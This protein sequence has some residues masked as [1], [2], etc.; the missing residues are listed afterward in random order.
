MADTSAD[1]GSSDNPAGQ[2]AV[3][4]KGGSAT[5]RATTTRTDGG[6]HAARIA[7]L[8]EIFKKRKNPDE[9][10]GTNEH[11]ESVQHLD[12]YT[13][14]GSTTL[15]SKDRK[16]TDFNELELGSNAGMRFP[17]LDV[18]PNSISSLNTDDWTINM[19]PRV[20]KHN[21][22]FYS[23][24]YESVVSSLAGHKKAYNSE[25]YGVL[26]PAVDL[27]W[28]EKPH[29]R[30]FYQINGDSLYDTLAEAPFGF[31][32]VNKELAED[33]KRDSRKKQRV[34][35]ADHSGA[36][37]YAMGMNQFRNK[38]IL[39]PVDDPSVETV[40]TQ[41]MCAKNAFRLNDMVLYAAPQQRLQ[42]KARY[43]A[44]RG[45]TADGVGFASV[46][47]QQGPAVDGQ[48]GFTNAQNSLESTQQHGFDGYSAAGTQF[49]PAGGPASAAYVR[50][51]GG[52]QA[53]AS[54]V[55]LTTNPNN[56]N[57]QPGI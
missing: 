8:E 51:V 38:T 50:G 33:F 18:E 39:H 21:L 2:A 34:R 43:N 46:A 13:D 49:A 12:G 55:G 53:G 1:G 37:I 56:P 24:A 42:F 32:K 6:T 45:A 48:F 44:T 54:A 9:Q 30:F 17:L 31:K 28:K 22:D 35:S 29:T 41:I 25:S 36:N 19:Q 27:N 7:R 16:I 11:T 14:K 10:A 52:M 47:G 3:S 26:K 15:P 20:K 5:G 23:L 4:G 57:V 40:P